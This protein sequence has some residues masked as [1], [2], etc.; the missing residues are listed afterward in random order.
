M[1]LTNAA[2]CKSSLRRSVT[3]APHIH[4]GFTE[5][6]G[7]VTLLEMIPRFHVLLLALLLSGCSLD[8][9]GS[10]ARVTIQMEPSSGERSFELQKGLG[11]SFL[12]APSTVNGFTCL[13]VNVMGPGIA[14][15]SY[16]PD[17]APPSY[18]PDEGKYC[19]YA[20][21]TSPPIQNSAGMKEANL[22]V[23]T[24]DRRVVQIVG[25]VQGTTSVCSFNGPVGRYDSGADGSDDYYE[26]GHTF[27]DIFQSI[28]ISVSNTFDSLG[29]TALR[30]QRKLD[31]GG[32]P[33]LTS[34]Q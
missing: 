26:L 11:L 16:N 21:I 18:S 31:C 13:A 30:E 1:F 33:T 8:P 10:S 9:Y 29:T 3:N 27:V 15:T 12:S 25:I 19:S 6:A 22:T 17:T 28:N 24:G 5:S 32:T 14:D 23:P 20:G 2:H 7:L 4:R 34:D